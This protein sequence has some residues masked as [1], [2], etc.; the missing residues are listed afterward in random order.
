[1]SAFDVGLLDGAFVTLGIQSLV[2]LIVGHI[3]RRHD[4]TGEPTK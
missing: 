1:M 2:Y 3:R 4:S